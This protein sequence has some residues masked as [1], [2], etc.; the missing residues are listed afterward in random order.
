[1]YQLSEFIDIQNEYGNIRYYKNDQHMIEQYMNQL[2]FEQEYIVNVLAEYVKKASFIIDVGAH[3]GSHTVMY[4]KLNPS[5]IVYSFEPQ[6]LLYKLLC[7]NVSDNCLQNVYSYNNAVGEGVYDAEMNPY[8]TDGENSMQEIEYGSSNVYNLAGVQVGSGGEKI[9][10]IS[11]DALKMNRC[12]FLKIDVEGYEPNVLI[13]ARNMIMSCRPVISFEVNSKKSPNIETP[14]V[15]I[16]NELG[17]S[18]HRAWQDNW[19]ALPN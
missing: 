4:K 11:L 6:K 3:V 15:E 17:Y 1:M 2:F 16:L 14:S 9:K 19:I 13:G 18:C 5:S 10:V 7:Y 12:E 8:S